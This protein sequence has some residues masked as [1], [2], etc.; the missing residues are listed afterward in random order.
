[1]FPV[2][3]LYSLVYIYLII[4]VAEKIVHVTI[5]LLLINLCN[6]MM[7]FYNPYLLSLT[8]IL[9]QINLIIESK[10]RDLYKNCYVV[11]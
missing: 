9:Y 5:Y 4:F 2:Y 8:N 10:R 11:R 1:M 7:F 6:Q 3:K